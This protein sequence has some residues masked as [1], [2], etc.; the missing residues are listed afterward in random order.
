MNKNLNQN[1]TKKNL[2]ET[3]KEASRLQLKVGEK[4]KL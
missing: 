3:S 2:Q 4:K 1:E